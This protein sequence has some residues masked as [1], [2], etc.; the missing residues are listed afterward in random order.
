[1]EQGHLTAKILHTKIPSD[2]MGSQKTGPWAKYH[3]GLPQ[4]FPDFR[5]QKNFQESLFKML[6][7]MHHHPLPS[8]SYF[9]DLEWGL[10]S[11]FS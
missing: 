8:T 6:I 3:Q 9:E 1:M 2:I 11:L 5:V 10:E 4:L 7:P